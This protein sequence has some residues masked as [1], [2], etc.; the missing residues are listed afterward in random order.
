MQSLAPGEADFSIA[1]V[2]VEARVGSRSGLFDYL[3]PEP[4]RGQVQVGQRVMVPFGKRSASGFVYGLSS[5]ASVRELKPLASLVD[6][7]P[8]LPTQVIEL[9]R[10]V[11]GH[12]LAPLDEVMRAI[13]PPRVRS[14]SRRPPT[15]R[16]RT[17][18]ILSRAKGK[19]V[20]AGPALEPAQRQAVERVSIAMD[21]HEAQAFLL[22]GVT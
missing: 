16:G 17:S 4:L 9:A 14:L 7:E 6:A 21:R 19:A 20:V 2:V 11:S 5:E 8:V 3:I 18:R 10:F 13:V 22:H 1:Q 12:Y 15:T